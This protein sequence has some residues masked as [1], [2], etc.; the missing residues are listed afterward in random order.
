MLQ[1]NVL[2]KPETKEKSRLGFLIEL[3]GR[4]DTLSRQERSGLVGN[5]RLIGESLNRHVPVNQPTAHPNSSLPREVNEGNGEGRN[6]QS[7]PE[8]QHTL[9]MIQTLLT[10]MIQQQQHQ[11]QMQESQRAESPSA[12]FL[13]L[14]MMMKDLGVRKFKGEQNTVLADKWL[15][16]LEMNFEKSRCPEDFKGH[17]VVHFLDEY[18]RVWWDSIVSRYHDQP[19]TWEMFKKEFESKYFPPGHV[20]VWSYGL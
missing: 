1:P 2:K 5:P 10:H 3:F 4:A 6:I 13:K 12:K 7:L 18:G 9:G 11:Q 19:I 17:I 15:R 14:I 20:I 8:T 16:N